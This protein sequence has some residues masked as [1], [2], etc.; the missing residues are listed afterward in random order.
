MPLSRALKKKLSI[1]SRAA[2]SGGNYCSEFATLVWFSMGT[3]MAD[4]L[5]VVICE[6]ARSPRSGQRCSAVQNDAGCDQGRNENG[7]GSL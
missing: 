6:F 7:V 3:L 2:L 5:Q 4:A 1:I